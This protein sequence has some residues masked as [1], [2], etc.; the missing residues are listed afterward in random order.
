MG[1]P[2]GNT[3]KTAKKEMAF[4]KGG[5]IYKEMIPCIVCHHPFP[6]KLSQPIR[7]RDMT[8]FDFMCT[9]CFDEETR[10]FLDSLPLEVR[11]LSK[12]RGEKKKELLV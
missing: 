8:R 4:E 11:G 5:T 12:K 9:P 10:H 6:M 1:R 3:Q 7:K 2:K